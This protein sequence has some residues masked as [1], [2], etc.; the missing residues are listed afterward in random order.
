MKNVNRFSISLIASVAFAAAVNGQVADAPDGNVA[1]IPANYTEAKVGNFTLP[2]PL[3]LNNGQPVKDAKTWNEQRRPEL[4]KYYESEI[5]GRIPA[6]APKVSWQVVSNDDHALDGTAVMKKLAGHMGG[7]GDPAIDVTLYTPAKFS[8]PV[9]ILVSISFNFAAAGARARGTATNSVATNAP[10]APQ[11][12]AGTNNSTRGAPAGGRGFGGPQRG[13][14]AEL[15]TNGFAYATIV[16]NSIE[17]D[18]SG[19]TNVNLVRKL[20]LAPGQTVPNPDEWGAIAAWAWGISRVVDYLETDKSVDSKRIAITGVSRLGKTVLWA[21]AND[22]RIAL[23]I[24]SCSGEG[25]AALARRNYGETIA[26]LTA[27]NRYPYQFAGNYS[28]YAK[29][30]NTLAVD[31]H[32]LIAL[33]APRPLLLQTGSTDTWSDPK[34]EFLAAVV[35]RPVYELL[36]GKGPETDELPPAGKFVGDTLGYYMHAGG[37]G[38]VPSDWDIYLQFMKAHLKP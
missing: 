14:P 37:H 32:C 30:P 33:M 35:A 27:T 6:T 34:G 12:N 3:K 21:G 15:I 23:V 7:P 18:V 17:T 16:Y 38:T 29:D 22:P 25:G 24:A 13:T 10:T 26:H 31:T 8:K 36:G 4:L 20:A 28:K 2:D 19:Q 5:Y 1:G 9:P 11:A